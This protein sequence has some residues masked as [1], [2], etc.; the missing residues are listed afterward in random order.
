[1]NDK[2][3]DRETLKYNSFH[4]FL[5]TVNC[6]ISHHN[7]RLILTMYTNIDE[8]LHMIEIFYEKKS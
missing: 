1:M 4:L 2:R 7:E 3:E 8:R 5:V 6:F